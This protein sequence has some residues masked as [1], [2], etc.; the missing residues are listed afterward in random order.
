LLAKSAGGRADDK[1]AYFAGK[2]DPKYVKLLAILKEAKSGL[3]ALGRIDMPGAK[4][5]PQ[6]RNF[7]R[8]FGLH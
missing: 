8:V 3:D 4:P 2:T 5:I 7:G 1:N 6:E